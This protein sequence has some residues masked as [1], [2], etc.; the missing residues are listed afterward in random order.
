MAP[1]M[2]RFFRL[3]W[4]FFRSFFVSFF[5]MFFWSFF[6]RFGVPF[7]SHFGVFLGAKSSQNR[8]MRFFD[9][10]WFSLGFS[11]FFAF[12]RV[13]FSSHVGSFFASF[14]V[15]IF[16]RFLVR[17]WGHFGNIL[18]PFWRSTSVIF[19]I[20]FLMIF[21]CRSKSG[22]R[23]AKSGQRPE[24]GQKRSKSGEKS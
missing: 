22:P 9:F 3:C 17:F 12:R 10:Y 20:D 7:W 18:E 14:F 4:L 13:L 16:G 6:G 21:A 23:A 1:G 8:T 15:S 19:G 24:S 2:R 5:V 11:M